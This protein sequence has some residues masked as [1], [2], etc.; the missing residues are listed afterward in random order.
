MSMGDY[1]IS[2]GITGKPEYTT[3]PPPVSLA[4]TGSVNSGPIHWCP[5]GA[6]NIT[7]PVS[8]RELFFKKNPGSGST[9]IY[10]MYGAMIKVLA[11]DISIDDWI[12][13]TA[14]TPGIYLI[15]KDNICIK[16]QLG[17]K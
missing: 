10:N 16:R 6:M 8:V 5:V 12:S 1:S 11:P 7:Y 13:N 2:V 3:A 4:N 9:K 14:L 15:T 17:M